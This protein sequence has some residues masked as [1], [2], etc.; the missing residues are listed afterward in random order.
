MEHMQTRLYQFLK[1]YPEL[2][3]LLKLVKRQMRDYAF[4]FLRLFGLRMPMEI[5]EAVQIRNI[6]A[7][8]SPLQRQE[9]K[10]VLFFTVKGWTSHLTWETTVAWGL[11]ARGADCQFVLCDRDLPICDTKYWY[12]DTQSLCEYCAFYAQRFLSLSHLPYHTLKEFI[13]EADRSEARA[14]VEQLPLSA[15][16]RFTFEGLPLGEIIKPSLV[17]FLLR[18]T[19]A[20]DTREIYLHKKF[21]ISAVLAVKAGQ[22]LLA[23][24]RPEVVVTVNGLFYAEWIL[25]ELARAA[26]LHVVTYETGFMNDTLIFGHDKPV[27]DM[28]ISAAWEQIKDTPLNQAEKR[29]LDEYLRARSL[30]QQ[31][32]VDYWP[33]LQKDEKVICDRLIIDRDKK[34]IT[35][36]S[37]ILWDTA[38]YAKDI[39]FPSMLDWIKETVQHLAAN[40]QLQV[41]VRIHPAEIRLLRQQSRD[42]VLRH[43]A[44][45]LAALPSNVKIVP[46]ES[47]LSSYVLMRISDLG[48]VYTSTVGLE[49]ALQGVPV[50]VAGE[51]HYRGKGFTYDPTSRS[52]YF[53]MLDELVANPA[54]V[55][56]QALEMAQRYAYLFFFRFMIPF[57]LISQGEHQNRYNFAN[58]VDLQAGK[59]S[60]LDVICAGI[61][62]GKDFLLPSPDRQPSP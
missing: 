35:L 44:Q 57:P 11:G 50:I 41:I 33:T 5:A 10:R 59:Q 6:I 18:G 21:L 37:N 61:L 58:L 19:I 36:F 14:I 43:L 62:E 23:L 29:R 38:I 54:P 4:R 31:A 52:E 13:N 34:I 30:G 28:D 15:Y 48:L 46:P 49:L 9:G 25:C 32:P 56:A 12:D 47:D 16:G 26:G 42:K 39:A 22:R 60:S 45:E 24:L 2:F 51:T 8:S 20:N 27:A 53:H 55:S 7:A 40:P 3:P 17:R 1:L